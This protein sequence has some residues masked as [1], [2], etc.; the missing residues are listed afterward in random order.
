VEYW[1]GSNFQN[2]RV[3]VDWSLVT[4]HSIT[5]TGLTPATAYNLYLSSTS[6]LGL[7]S[8]EGYTFETT[9]GTPP[10]PPQTGAYNKTWL[11]NGVHP[12]TNQSTRLSTDYIGGESG[13]NPGQGSVSGGKTWSR[14]DSSTDYVDLNAAFGASTY[15]A[16]YAF[17]YVYSPSI[18][19]VNLWIGSNDGV[20]VWL[21]GAVVWTND[22]YRSFSIDKDKTTVTLPAGWSRILA[23]I[24]QA[25]GSW[26]FSLKFC[27]SFGN[28]L[29]GVAYA[30]APSTGSDT[31]APVISN[32]KVTPSNTS[33]AIE[34]DTSEASNTMVDYGTTSALG[35]SYT[36]ESLVTHHSATL[37]ELNSGTTHYF[38]VGSADS[39][40]NT[41][42]QGSYTFQTTTNAPPPVSSGPYVM[43]WL[44]NGYY[45]NSRSVRMSTDYLGN[46][47]AV[48]PGEGTVSGGNAWFRLDSD[49]DYIDLKTPFNS[50]TG[51][52]GYACAYVYSP[53]AQ[54]AHMWMGSDDGIKVWLN[55]SVVWNNDIYRSMSLDVDRTTV[56]LSVGWNRLLVKVTQADQG[57]GFSLRL[58]DSVGNALPGIAIS[59]AP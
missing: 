48:A 3:K 2:Y 10:P 14:R 7:V 27:D 4:H 23:K 12:N 31:T 8:S 54:T 41:A 6:A 50:P 21:N 20:R 1:N 44:V 24:S 42:W 53:V 38:K 5:L 18:Q 39:S 59:V 11:L 47:G 56:N 57:W 22:A 25:T 34:W 51:C 55:G 37:A 29:P 49:R 26:G 15:C 58:C 40:G 13:A 35:E 28:A 19:N 16:A 9:S 52:A 30:P 17:A 43:T 32:I 33:A 45:K 46:E 36:D